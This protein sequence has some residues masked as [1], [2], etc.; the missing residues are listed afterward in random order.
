MTPKPWSF[1]VL[2]KFVT[3]PKKF[4]EMD[5]SKRISEPE[6][7]GASYGNFVHDHSEA[8]LKAHGKYAF[9]P[10]PPNINGHPP[11]ERYRAYFDAILRLPGTMYIEQKM[12]LDI[13]LRPVTYFDPRVWVRG[14]ADVITIDGTVARGLDHKTGKRKVGSRQMVLMALLI[15]HHHPE[16]QTVKTAFFWAK[17]NE[18]D[19]GEYQR[20]DMVAMWNMFVTDLH[21]Y[22]EA[23]QKNVWQPRQNGLC[24]GWCPV[25]DCEFW[26]PKKVRVR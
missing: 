2:D 3:C 15:F 21:Q 10:N 18:I 7:D 4:Y 22:R 14:K 20:A 16:V 23:F 12:A 1:S 25:T 13:Q 24:H 19:K 11:M 5:V 8:Y 9:P 6:G 26:K 17:T